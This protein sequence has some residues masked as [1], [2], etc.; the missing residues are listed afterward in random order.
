VNSAT[1]GNCNNNTNS[2]RGGRGG[3]GGRNSAGRGGFGRGGGGR[4]TFQPAVFCQICGKEGHP[5]HAISNA[6]TATTAGHRRSKLH[7]Q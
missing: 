7:R 2:S 6:S 5:A 4:R 3:G 1:R